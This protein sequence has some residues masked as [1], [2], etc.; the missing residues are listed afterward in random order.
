MPARSHPLDYLILQVALTPFFLPP[1][2]GTPRKLAQPFFSLSTD[3]SS[4]FCPIRFIVVSL[5]SCIA[6]VGFRVRRYSTLSFLPP[7][8]VSSFFLFRQWQNRDR[9]LCLS[10]YTVGSSP[11]PLALPPFF[12]PNST[13]SPPE[14]ACDFFFSVL[15][16]TTVFSTFVLQFFPPSGP[17]SA[18]PM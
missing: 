1:L 15:P 6:D 8:S 3:L 17:P 16:R 7:R 9:F 4:S 12:L 10:L 13:F 14:M 2:T 18:W 5:T 11:L